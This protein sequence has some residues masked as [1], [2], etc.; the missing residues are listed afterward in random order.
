MTDYEA[1]AKHELLAEDAAAFQRQ[2]EVRAPR[3]GMA[4]G[5][6]LSTG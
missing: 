1:Q 4:D 5:L 6:Q 3:T 2:V